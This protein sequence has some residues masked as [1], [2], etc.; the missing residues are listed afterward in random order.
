M[1]SGICVDFGNCVY[2]VPG[3]KPRTK[4][5]SSYQTVYLKQLE[6]GSRPFFHAQRNATQS[7]GLINLFN[8]K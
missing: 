7:G 8:F 2:F 4:V 6:K 3:H 1:L 5:K